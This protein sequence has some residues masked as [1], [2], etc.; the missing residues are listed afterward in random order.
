MDS[1]GRPAAVVT[2]PTA[3]ATSLAGIAG[4]ASGIRMTAGTRDTGSRTLVGRRG[5]KHK[6][7]RVADHLEDYCRDDPVGQK[8]GALGG[9][10]RWIGAGRQRDVGLDAG[11]GSDDGHLV[12]AAVVSDGTRVVATTDLPAAEGRMGTRPPGFLNAYWRGRAPL[13]HERRAG[14]HR[15]RVGRAGG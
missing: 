2:V 1:G 4:T 8:A 15:A 9:H 6:D 11:G 7:G 12:G 13:A 3:V 14:R 10:G 5:K